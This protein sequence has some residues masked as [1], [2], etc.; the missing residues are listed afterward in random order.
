MLPSIAPGTDDAGDVA[1]HTGGGEFGSNLS[2]KRNRCGTAD[3][4]GRPLEVAWVIGALVP[5]VLNLDVT[6]GYLGVAALC[7]VSGL[8]LVRGGARRPSASRA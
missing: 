1:R 8:V 7:L 5:T 4:K 6:P 2:A 3:W